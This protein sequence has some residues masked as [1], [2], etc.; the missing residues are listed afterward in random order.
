MVEQEPRTKEQA[1][2]RAARALV[3]AEMTNAQKHPREL[4]E[5]IARGA[6]ETRTVDEIEDE[7]RLDRGMPLIHGGAT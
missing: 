4:A 7:I 6:T 5:E 3:N 1:I 2:D